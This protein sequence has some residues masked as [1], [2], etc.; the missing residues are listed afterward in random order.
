ML[1]LF[2]NL[3]FI[4]NFFS[5]FIGY[6]FPG[7]F[8]WTGPSRRVLHT[9]IV[10]VLFVLAF[11]FL[12]ITILICKYLT[13]TYIKNELLLKKNIKK[14]IFHHF[15]LINSS[16]FHFSWLETLGVFLNLIKIN[17]KC[18]YKILK[19]YRESILIKLLLICKV[20]IINV[21]I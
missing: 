11:F 21:F 10:V 7:S 3:K 20:F 4:G 18:Y 8:V 16:F 17:F 15:K 13:D 2:R 14:V 9:I 5:S 6:L 19:I 12:V 1:C